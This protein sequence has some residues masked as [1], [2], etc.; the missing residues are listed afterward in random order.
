MTTKEFRKKLDEMG[1]NSKI[2]GCD[3]NVEN[4]HGDEWFCIDSFNDEYGVGL[5]TFD[6]MYLSN[7]QTE[8]LELVVAYIK[9]PL[10]ERKVI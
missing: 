7:H 1:L 2:S 3:I 6:G 9:S 10:D 8:L 4:G 5:Y